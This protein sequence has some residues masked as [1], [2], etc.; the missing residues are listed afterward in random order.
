MSRIQSS[1][2]IQC[3]V[4]LCLVGCRSKTELSSDDTVAAPHASTNE[5]NE[6]QLPASFPQRLAVK[7]LPNAIQLHERVISGGQPDG[8]AAFRELSALGIKTVI[9]VDGAKPD[10][11]LAAKYNLRYVHLPHGYNG[12][13]EQRVTELAKAVRD[14]EGP[15]YIHCH[16]GKHRSPTAAT[17]ACVANGLIDP[18][19]ATQ[20]LKFAGTSD[21]Y[22]GLYKSAAAARRIDDA[23]LNAMQ[24]E[25]P[26]TAK[27][28]PM[29]ESMVNLEH[30]FDHLKRFAAA[31]WQPLADHPDLDAAHEAL[32][33]TEH[34]TEMLRL[35][36]VAQGPE[37][38]RA[39][40]QE[41]ETDA[42]KLEEAL[43]SR[44]TASATVA[45]TANEAF[46]R[47][48]ENCTKCHRQF[49]DVPL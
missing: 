1:L 43:R 19:A 3:A 38:F 42:R 9:S 15:I 35:E 23:I 32:M 24:A 40:L 39:M 44:S 33:L 37:T 8:E 6:P 5:T 41:S 12:I 2:I 4:L 22:Q 26:S 28:Q 17:V 16:H 49:R 30:T 29:A 14:F 20:V 47:I 25:F 31:E 46:K 36:S 27:L 45:A 21:N 48:T 18:L 7:H 11:A 13:P 10:T 34:F